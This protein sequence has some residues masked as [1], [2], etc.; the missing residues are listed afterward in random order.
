MLEG[1][2]DKDRWKMP[3]EEEEVDE[4]WGFEDLECEC[5]FSSFATSLRDS[6]STTSCEIQT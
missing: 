3:D 4:F 2:V 5:D 1:E 6:I